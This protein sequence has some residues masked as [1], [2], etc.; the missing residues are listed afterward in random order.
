MI[1]VYL[2]DNIKLW[3]W[4]VLV[5]H[6]WEAYGKTVVLATPFIPSSF[7]HAPRNPT[8]INSGYKAWEF[9]IYLISLD[10]ALF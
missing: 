7:R 5:D 1:K 2:P 10:L 3:N 4:H 6:I 9:Q 8:K